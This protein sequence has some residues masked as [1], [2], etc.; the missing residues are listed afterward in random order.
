MSNPK[1]ISPF[2]LAPSTGTDLRP[3]PLVGATPAEGGGCRFVAWAPWARDL[4][5]HL[6]SGSEGGTDRVAPMT[7]T[8]AGYF[9]TEIEDVPAGTRYL[10]R[11]ENGSERPDPASPFQ[12]E[13]VHGPSQVVDFGEFRWTDTLWKG[14]ELEESVFHELHVGTYTTQGT[15]EALIPH[16][17]D[18]RELGITTVELMPV[19]QFPGGRNW[20]YDGVQPFAPQNSYGGPRGLQKFVDAAHHHG[21]AVALD[22]VYNHVGPE[23]N[24]FSAYGPYFTDK[25]QTPWGQAINFDGPDSDAVRDFFIQNALHWLENYHIDVLRLDAV[26]GIFDCSASHFLADLQTAVT[27]LETQVRRK[28]YLVAESDLNDSR[29]LHSPAAGGYGL[30]AQWSD[31]FHHSLHALLT[32]ERAGYYSDFGEVHHLATTMRNG[33]FYAGQHSNFRRR[34]HGSSPAGLARSSFVVCIQN[35]D[36]IGNRARGDRLGELVDFEGLKLA[37]GVTVLA[38]FVPLLFMGEEYGEKAPFQYFASHGDADLI[39][40]VRKGRKDEFSAFTWEGEIP[41]PHD[42][43]TFL[44]SKLNHALKS[45]EPHRTLRALYRELLAIRREYHLAGATKI[46]IHENGSAIIMVAAVGETKMLAA[47]FE[48]GKAELTS[49]RLDLPAGTWNLKINSADQQWNGPGN[50]VPDKIQATESLTVALA[51]QSFVLFE[52]LNPTP[53]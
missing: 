51:S 4:S 18:L 28:L 16:L 19:A 25:Y 24:Y 37:A 44:N 33:W 21:L 45:R 10:Y 36:Q 27:L 13:G 14:L 35:H 31:D 17:S 3:D 5:V 7:K 23:G 11:L 43:K 22:V 40:A 52:R 9:E 42:E 2:G 26:H 38:P 46:N 53:E 30:H 1:S 20:G 48:F 32:G 15:F 29:I 49:H 34:K 12:P 6:L 41:D 8:S 39:E 50:A 47:I